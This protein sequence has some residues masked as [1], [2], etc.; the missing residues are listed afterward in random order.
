MISFIF[1]LWLRP[2]AK[3]RSFSGPNIRLR[4]KV[5]IVPTVQHCILRAISWEF[6]DEVFSLKIWGHF[7]QQCILITFQRHISKMKHSILIT[8]KKGHIPKRVHSI[9]IPS[10]KE[11]IPKG[12]IPF[13]SHSKK[14]RFHFGYIQSYTYQVL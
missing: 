14:S 2:T 4:P 5:N 12:H 8:F 11:H 3:G 1:N 6:W 13:W 9:L 7:I 10:Q